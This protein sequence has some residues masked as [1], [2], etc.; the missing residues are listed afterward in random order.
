MLLPTVVFAYSGSGPEKLK[1]GIS[2]NFDLS[3]PNPIYVIKKTVS[4][5][6]ERL[7][8][9]HS[10]ATQNIDSTLK[11]WSSDISDKYNAQVLSIQNKASSLNNSIQ[12]KVSLPSLAK[13]PE[14]SLAKGGSH[15]PSVNSL[16]I[17]KSLL[18]IPQSI[19]KVSNAISYETDVFTES[20]LYISEQ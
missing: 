14:A 12:Q 20:L 10:A 8:E 17:S 15:Q 19:K 2:F 18:T 5:S 13:P 4:D 16:S 11:K 3:L 9:S 1:F 6:S 7:N